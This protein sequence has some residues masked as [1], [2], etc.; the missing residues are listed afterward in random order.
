LSETDWE[1]HGGTFS[2]IKT[3]VSSLSVDSESSLAR[4]SALKAFSTHSSAI[5]KKYNAP[6]QEFIKSSMFKNITEADKDAPD[7]LPYKSMT[8]EAK[9]KVLCL[10]LLVTPLFES[11]DEST[12]YIEAAKYALKLIRLTLE[13]EGELVP[14]RATSNVTKSYLRLYSGLL[15]LKIV[16]IP[17][18]MSLVEVHDMDLLGLVVQDPDY[19]VRQA[20]IDKVLSYLAKLELST[21]YV[22]L[23]VLVAHDPDADL[24]KRAK[25]HLARGAKQQR[26]T[27]KLVEHS[28]VRLIH[29]LSR[30]SDFTSDKEDVEQFQKY[31]HLT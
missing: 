9:A 31:C 6:I 2:L 4:I 12:D 19:N 26:G 13:R 14:K 11:S 16:K 30:H 28:F 21:S 7:W 24:K 5:Y 18:Y 8:V 20:F 25:S 17:E 15:Y 10:K 22:I 3:I 23:L 27:E 1:T 29:L